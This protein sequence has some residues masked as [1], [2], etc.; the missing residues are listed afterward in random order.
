[1]NRRNEFDD[2]DISQAIGNIFSILNPRHYMPSNN[3]VF[4]FALVIVTI[5]IFTSVIWYSYPKEKKLQNDLAV[6]V[7]KADTKPMRIKPEDEGG[8]DILF[9]DSTVFDTIASGASGAS[10][11]SDD[12]GERKI[13]NLLSDNEEPLSRSALFAG[14]KTDL[15]SALSQATEENGQDRAEIAINTHSSAITTAPDK[16]HDAAVKSQEKFQEKAIE[17][18]PTI[19]PEPEQANIIKPKTKPAAIAD[20]KPEA[21]K[22][23]SS[24]VTVQKKYYVQLGSLTSQSDADK[25]WTSYSKKYSTALS[26]AEH[27]IEKAI[28]KDRG[29][30]YRVQAGPFPEDKARSICNTIKNKYSGG[31][32]VIK[33]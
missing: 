4:T 16:P 5:G 17:A 18:V 12:N 31:C 22:T 11:A 25:A 8:M 15:N 27:R 32:I 21:Q 20:A 2:P 26:G 9:E 7:I 33:A 29:T 28:I 23:T 1:M 14:L 13:E 24:P 10:G 6:P 3:P 19:A 30:Y